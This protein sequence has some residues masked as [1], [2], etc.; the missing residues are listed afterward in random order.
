MNQECLIRGE[1]IGTSAIGLSC[2]LPLDAIKSGMTLI[3]L[4][5]QEEINK[6]QSLYVCVSITS[7][8]LYLPSYL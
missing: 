3:N 7:D 1:A 6:S 2:L 4:A 5:R 8:L